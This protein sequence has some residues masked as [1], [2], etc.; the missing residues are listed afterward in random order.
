MPTAFTKGT[1]L[2]GGERPLLRQE[3]DLL[4]VGL[5]DG[6]QRVR[7]VLGVRVASKGV[8]VVHRQSLQRTAAAT[9]RSRP[10]AASTRPARTVGST[11]SATC[12]M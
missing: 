1:R 10:V 5:R 2:L 7:A 11:L 4:L 12:T 3:V 8:V 9:P 6:V